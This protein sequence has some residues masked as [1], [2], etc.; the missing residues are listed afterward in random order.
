MN[1]FYIFAIL[2][3]SSVSDLEV[4]WFFSRKNGAKPPEYCSV[5]ALDS[6]EGPS[7]EAASIALLYL[8]FDLELRQESRILFTYAVVF[9]ILSEYSSSEI[10]WRG[11]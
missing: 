6:W 7:R 10:F 4:V 5:A 9:F 8:T 3:L 11:G 2:I 1:N